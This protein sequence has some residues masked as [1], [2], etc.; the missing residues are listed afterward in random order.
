[1]ITI[2]EICYWT[3]LVALLFW[4]LVDFF[5]ADVLFRGYF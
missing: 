1:M 4:V 2:A 5:H 3:V